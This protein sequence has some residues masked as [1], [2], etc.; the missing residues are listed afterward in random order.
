MS[1]RDDEERD[2]DEGPRYAHWIP[3][4]AVRNLTMERALHSHESYAATAK[5]LLEENLPLAVIS[6]THM[7]LYDTKPEVRLAAAKYV[8]DQS[9]GSPN[10]KE[11]VPASGKHAW[12][13]I[14]DAVLVDVEPKKSGRSRK[15]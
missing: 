12:E 1:N 15:E 10:R 11:D 14:H 3:E 7:A 8:I 6:V 4:E 2:P 5:R 9:M 13:S